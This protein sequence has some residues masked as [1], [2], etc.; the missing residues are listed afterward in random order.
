MNVESKK[1]KLL[2]HPINKLF[3]AYLLPSVSG[4]F[5]TSVYILADS[6]IIGKKIGQEALTALN[7]VL[8]IFSLFFS[9]GL[10]FGVGGSILLSIERG[11]GNE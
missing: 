1:E 10:L 8:P 7:I 2:T 11:K 9:I 4:T 3:Y 5:V 6:V